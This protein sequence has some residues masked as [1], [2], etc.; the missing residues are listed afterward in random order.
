MNVNFNGYGENVTTFIADSGLTAAGVPVK[1]SGDGTVTKCSADDVFCGI[2]IGLH[3]GY[4]AVQT[5][6]YVRM[7]AA[8]KIAV[9]YKKLA[10]DGNGGVAVNN[11]GRELLVV[12]ATSTEVGFIL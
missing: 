6:G 12:D 11:S 7:P 2:C 1:L 4:A 8:S 10:A 9:G 5:A 3:G